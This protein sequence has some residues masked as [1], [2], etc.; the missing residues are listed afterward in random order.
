VAATISTV[1]LTVLIGTTAVLS[2]SEEHPIE[3]GVAV[4]PASG[5]VDTKELLA[6]D[7]DRSHP[8]ATRV[9][10]RITFSDATSFASAGSVTAEVHALVPAPTFVLTGV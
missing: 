10:A 4:R 7:A 1:E 9:Q 6:I 5:S 3:K 2:A 8:Y